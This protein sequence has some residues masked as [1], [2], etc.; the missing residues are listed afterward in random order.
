MISSTTSKNDVQS[1]IGDSL[2]ITAT[3]KHVLEGYLS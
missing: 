1:H 2:Q 3:P